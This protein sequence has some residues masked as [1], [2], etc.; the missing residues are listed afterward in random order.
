MRKREQIKTNLSRSC[1]MERELDKSNVY[2]VN[3]DLTPDI[4]FD[5]LYKTI[6]EHG[7]V[8]HVL[9]SAIFLLYL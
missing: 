6:I 2:Y 4:V 5:L 1:Y 3:M 7:N 8:N 9:W